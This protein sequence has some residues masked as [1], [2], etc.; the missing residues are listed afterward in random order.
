MQIVQPNSVL[1]F[2]IPIHQHCPVL[3]V[4]QLPLVLMSHLDPWAA[5]CLCIHVNHTYLCNPIN[6]ITT[7][8]RRQPPTHLTNSSQAHTHPITHT[9]KSTQTTRIPSRAQVAGRACKAAPRLG[10][11]PRAKGSSAC[12][13][14][15]AQRPAATSLLHDD[16]GM[17]PT[18]LC[19]R[20]VWL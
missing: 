14:C 2:I 19:L 10:M 4:H 3:A 16:A 13:T 11:A 8:V 5:E 1:F 18:C 20:C 17:V 6:K 15:P 12:N 9:H 7:S